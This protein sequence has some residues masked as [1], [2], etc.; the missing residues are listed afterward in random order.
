[1]ALDWE[2]FVQ[3][4]AAIVATRWPEVMNANG[5]GGIWEYD[6]VNRRSHEERTLPFAVL[7]LGTADDAEWGSVNCA[8]EF[9][10]EMLYVKSDALS[11]SA[12]RAT[13]EQVKL[14]VLNGSYEPGFQCLRVER[15]DTSPQNPALALIAAKN[16]P[17]EG[18]TLT[19]R[20]L[21][22]ETAF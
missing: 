11:L 19:F 17:F 18:G 21:V 9:L 13:L 5:G 14:P 12:L 20:F 3:D 6:Q 10:V 15:I 4:L 1:M 22:G 7:T 8:Q 2:A 16:A